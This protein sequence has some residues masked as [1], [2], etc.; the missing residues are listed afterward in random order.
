MAI[1]TI[2]YLYF[3]YIV[4]SN[5]TSSI[6]KNFEKIL[7]KTIKGTELATYIN[8]ILD[9]DTKNNVEKDDKGYYIDNNENSI[10]AEIKFIDSDNIFRI[11]QIANKGIG[12]FINLYANFNFKCTKIEY[13]NKTKLISYLYFEEVY[14]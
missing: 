6:N 13:H 10:I 3:N 4:L 11:E 7:D 5:T 2:S 14:N 12:E 1:A 8:Q 9:K